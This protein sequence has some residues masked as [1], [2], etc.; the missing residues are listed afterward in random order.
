MFWKKYKYRSHY[1]QVP[2]VIQS[3]DP[4]HLLLQSCEVISH[5]V[6]EAVLQFRCDLL[7]LLFSVV[8]IRRTVC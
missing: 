4:V 5:R 8:C 6:V 2:G 3:C 7:E 1:I